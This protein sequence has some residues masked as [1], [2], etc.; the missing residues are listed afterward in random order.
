[1]LSDVTKKIEHYR[2]KFVAELEL[3]KEKEKYKKWN[4]N[5]PTIYYDI[6]IVK[7]PFGIILKVSK[8]NQWVIILSFDE[9]E[10]SEYF[11]IEKLLEWH[12][13]IYGLLDKNL[14]INLNQIEK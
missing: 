6:K 5:A 13:D 9:P 10:K 7:K 3:D 11:I 8:L 2:E 1:P 14:A 4:D 12:F